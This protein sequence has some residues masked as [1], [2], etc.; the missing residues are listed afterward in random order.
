MAF[1][2]FGH[3]LL[4]AAFVLACVTVAA[5]G[6]DTESDSSSAALADDYVA[7]FAGFTSAM[8][9]DAE[10][11]AT[12]FLSSPDN[13]YRDFFTRLAALL[14]RYED[15]LRSLEPPDRLSD[16]HGGLLHSLGDN[17]E[18]MET[19]IDD[20]DVNLSRASDQDIA[21]FS[22][23]EAA[24]VDV[25]NS[26]SDVRSQLEIAPREAPCELLFSELALN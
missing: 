24:S 18:L 1:S 6:G 9:D 2:L 20:A 5:C 10:S 25:I 11:L 12:E 26:C 16:E 22:E 23:L 19:I 8:A 14:A 4:A 17:R 15:G 7:A 3:I 13:T 21:G